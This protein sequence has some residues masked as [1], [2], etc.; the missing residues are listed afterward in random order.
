LASAFA[1]EERSIS[2]EAPE[3]VSEVRDPLPLRGEKSLTPDPLILLASDV[4][5]LGGDVGH[6]P[7]SLSSPS[8]LDV[9]IRLYIIGFGLSNVS[10]GMLYILTINGRAS[11]SSELGLSND[12]P[13]AYK[14][15][16]PH[17][18]W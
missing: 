2:A 5:F 8:L 17:L 4:R 3:L 1:W 11:N 16:N 15:P 14:S 13:E 6:C 7:T 9:T 12:V 18:V 10:F